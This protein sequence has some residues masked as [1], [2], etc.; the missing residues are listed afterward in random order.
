VAAPSG[1]LV[2]FSF[3]RARTFPDEPQ[4]GAAKAVVQ[5]GALNTNEVHWTEEEESLCNTA[6]RRSINYGRIADP[7]GRMSC[8][9]LGLTTGGRERAFIG[10]FPGESSA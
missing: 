1:A 6:Q 3:D 9:L 7:L 8:R 2:I 4:R 10:G 5:Q